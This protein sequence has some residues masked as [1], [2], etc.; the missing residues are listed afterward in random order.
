L[1]RVAV[2]VAV[3]VAV[4]VV[5]DVVVDVAVVVDVV[6]AL[7]GAVGVVVAVAVGVAGRAEVNPADV[8]ALRTR[9]GLAPAAFGALIGVDAR[10]VL[11]WESGA[12][13]PTGAAERVLAALCVVLREDADGRIAEILRSAASVGGLSYL[14]VYLLRSQ[15]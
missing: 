14:L 6:V 8:L 5:V 15:K 4:A 3:V 12:T 11:R 2:G 9:I 7:R 1:D 10:T 13:V